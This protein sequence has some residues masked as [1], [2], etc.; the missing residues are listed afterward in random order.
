MNISEFNQPVSKNVIRIIDEKGLKQ[1]NV[2]ERA[3]FTKQEFNAMLNGRK[4]IKI[5]DIEHITAA[6]GVSVHELYKK[7]E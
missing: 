7:G 1:K 4:L 6:L 2:A 3:G 5:S